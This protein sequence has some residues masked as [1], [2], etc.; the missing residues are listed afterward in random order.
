ML[1]WPGKLGFSRERTSRLA[2]AAR[3][4]AQE[5]ERMLGARVRSVYYQTAFMDRAIA[6]MDRTRDLLRDI[7][8]VAQTSY[9][10]GEGLQQDVLQAQVAVARMTEDLTVMEQNRIAYAR[11]AQR[12]ARSRGPG[13]GGRPG[14]P[15]PDPPR[16]P[17]DSLVARPGGAVR[18]SR[19][20]P[21]GSGQRR[22]GYAPP[23]G[24][25]IP[26]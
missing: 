25:S 17:I 23:A 4:D 12:P 21:S 20:R 9:A 11:P 13:L 6:I 7:L 1:P 18:R 24:R 5:A 19:R 15:V 16:P 22:P 3:L 26:T 14:A 8:T 2:A 10:V